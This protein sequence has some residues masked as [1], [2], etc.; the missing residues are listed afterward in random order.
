MPFRDRTEA[1]WKLAEPL[2]G[3]AGRPDVIVLGIPRGG[4]PVA[5][6]VARELGV[7]LDVFLARKL[8]VPGDEELAFGAVAAGGGRYL[9]EFITRHSGINE[10]DVERIT[11]ETRQLLEERA[12]LYRKGRPPLALQ[13]RTVILVDD[14]MATGASTLAAVQALRQSGPRCI[15]L[16]VP[17]A[18]ASAARRLERVVDRLVVLERPH[19]FFAVGQFY[20]DFRQ[21]S[22]AEVIALLERAAN[23]EK[24]PAP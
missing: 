13:D 20:E 16:A 21:T 3:Y 19:D 12:R 6:E 4:V 17:V 7:E 22:D 2:R 11:A 14:G 8:G 24:R 9:D 5:F 1:G 15:V 10:Q 23:A 18:P